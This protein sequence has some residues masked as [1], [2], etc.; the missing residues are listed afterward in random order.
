M[1]R[2]VERVVLRWGGYRSCPPRPARCSSVGP[3]KTACR[4]E[5]T[6][7]GNVSRVPVQLAVARFGIR[8]SALLDNQPGGFLSPLEMVRPPLEVVRPPL[9]GEWYSVLPG[10]AAAIFVN[11][12]LTFVSASAVSLSAGMVPLRAVASCW[13]AATT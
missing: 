9:E 11:N 2:V 8:Q 7:N 10:V 5:V 13:A 1:I 3:P 6:V 4:P 12:S